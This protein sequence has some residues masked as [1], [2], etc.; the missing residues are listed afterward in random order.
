MENKRNHLPPPTT[1]CTMKEERNTKGF[2]AAIRARGGPAKIKI[3]W[4]EHL[5]QG[6]K[7]RKE[8]GGGAEKT[9]WQT[10]TA[11]NRWKHSRWEVHTIMREA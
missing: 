2:I 9:P 3:R 11:Q 7:C 1:D 6:R 5:R 4:G 10:G 8:A